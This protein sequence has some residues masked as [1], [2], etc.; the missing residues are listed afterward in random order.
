MVKHNRTT[1]RNN[2]RTKRNAKSRGGVGASSFGVHVFGDMDNQHTASGQGNSIAINSADTYMANAD[3]YNEKM[4]T[5]GVVGGTRKLHGGNSIVTEIAI[6]AV[7]LY[8]NNTIGKR[9][10]VKKQKKKTKRVRFSRR[11][12]R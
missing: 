11:I 9:K 12:K 4:V 1:K 2:R 8:V 5:D 7:L 10:R 3:Q 6:P